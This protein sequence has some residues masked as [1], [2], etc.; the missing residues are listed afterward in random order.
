[1][2]SNHVVY[3]SRQKRENQMFKV[4][5]KYYGA[6]TKERMFE[7]YESAKKFF[8]FATFKMKGV[9]SAEMKAV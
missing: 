6:H 9:S 4:T 1:M 5:Y 3:K 7:N 8:Y 2:V